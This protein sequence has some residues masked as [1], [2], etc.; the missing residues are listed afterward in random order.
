MA[1]E[2]VDQVWLQVVMSTCLDDQDPVCLA[3]RLGLMDNLLGEQE[4]LLPSDFNRVVTLE[5]VPMTEG[6]LAQVVDQPLS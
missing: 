4:G 1:T 5:V 6:P 3:V 2:Q